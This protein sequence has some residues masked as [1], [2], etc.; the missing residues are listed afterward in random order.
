MP[1]IIAFFSL[2]V[3]CGAAF[4]QMNPA[5]WLEIPGGPADR[6]N[7]LN[8]KTVVREGT[9]RKAWSL[10]TWEQ[11]QTLSGIDYQ[12]VMQVDLYNCSSRTTATKSMQVYE[13]VLAT[14]RVTRSIDIPV[15]SLKWSE[16][17]PG[18]PIDK[19]LR[20]VCAAELAVQGGV[21]N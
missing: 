19:I 6:T 4:A 15:K 8:V 17:P 13:G 20:A 3:A 18:T 2:L 7:F 1:L 10:S 11:K 14:G 12:S 21:A 5:D 9:Y 16:V